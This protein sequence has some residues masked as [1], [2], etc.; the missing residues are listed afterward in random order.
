[1]TQS[2]KSI[3]EILARLKMTPALD[4][5]Q[6]R[7]QHIKSWVFAHLPSHLHALVAEVLFDK[8]GHLILMTTQAITAHA[9]RFEQDNLLEALQAD[10]LSHHDRAPVWVKKVQIRVVPETT[11][12]KVEA[13]LPTRTH[14]R[15]K[16]ET[17]RIMQDHVRNLP[18]MPLKATLRTLL[19]RLTAHQD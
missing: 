2:I 6:Q 13:T 15:L 10:A 12:T 14:S 7:M 4:R 8:K 17:A 3:K 9:L 18:E 19:E 1:M 11:Y 5:Y 16:P